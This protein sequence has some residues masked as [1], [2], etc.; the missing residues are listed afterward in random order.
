VSDVPVPEA[1]ESGDAR[2]VRFGEVPAELARAL[3]RWLAEHAV[4]EGGELKPGSVWRVGAWVA[5]FSGPGRRLVDRLR[6]SPALRAARLAL[7]L[8]PVRTARPIV[9]LE[10]R[11]GGK[12]LDSLLV[13]EFVAG[14]HLHELWTTEPAARA[15]FP[16]FLAAMHEAGVRHADLHP[17]NSIWNGHAWVLIDLDGVRLGARQASGER[18]LVESWAR[19]YHNMTLF[20]PTWAPGMLALFD[21]YLDARTLAPRRSTLWPRVLERARRLRAGSGAATPLP[22]DPR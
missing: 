8:G 1:Y 10:Q 22:P 3:P 4:P 20:E 9:A 7:R 11:A 21:A 2:G 14:P 19:L 5:K 16:L 15:A 17:G 12:L 18:A 6:P 13:C